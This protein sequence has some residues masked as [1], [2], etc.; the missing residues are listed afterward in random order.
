MVITIEE[1]IIR[2]VRVQVDLPQRAIAHHRLGCS[3]LVLLIIAN[4]VLDG[5]KESVML[6]YNVAAHLLAATPLD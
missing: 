5:W 1:Q 2:R 4:E 3:A 6:K